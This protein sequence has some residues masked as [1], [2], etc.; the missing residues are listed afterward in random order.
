MVSVASIVSLTVG[1]AGRAIGADDDEVLATWLLIAGCLGLGRMLLRGLPA[2]ACE[3]TVLIAGTG[4]VAQQVAARLQAG[5]GPGLQPIGFVGDGIE[6]REPAPALPVLGALWDLEQVIERSRPRY[7]VFAS[8]LAV[9]A[10]LIRLVHCCWNLDVEVFVVPRLYDSSGTAATSTTSGGCR[11]GR[12]SRH[13]RGH[14][15]RAPRPCSIA[16][17][18]RQA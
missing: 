16:S 12:C 3:G 18:P 17:R 5:Y 9:D 13:D 10:D 6:R 8:S 7:V 14:G 4:K 2:R 15:P 11:C 1:A